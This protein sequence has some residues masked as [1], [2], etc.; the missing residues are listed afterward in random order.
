[1]DIDICSGPDTIC[2]II[3]NSNGN[4]FVVQNIKAAL[5]V[6][7]GVELDYSTLMTKTGP[8]VSLIPGT[9]S[10]LIGDLA[11]GEEVS[12]SLELTTD[13]EILGSAVEY[14][15]D[16]IYEELCEGSTNT[17]S[18]TSSPINVL[19]PDIGISLST[20][21]A[22]SGVIDYEFSINNTVSNTGTND[23]MDVF[24][25]VEDNSNANL[26][27]IEIGGVMQSISTSSI[28][29]F[30]CYDIGALAMGTDVVVVENWVITTC[31]APVQ[32][33][34][35][36]ASFG[37]DG[38]IDCQML[39]DNAFP[40][41]DLTLVAPVSP[42]DIMTS[43]PADIDICSG[44]DTICVIIENT[45]GNNFVVQNIKAALAVP[46]G[47]ELDYST[48]MT[49]TGPMVTLIPGTDSLL[50]GDLADGEEVSFSLELTTDCEILGS[51]VEY[52]VD[53]V[54]EELCEGATNTASA[55]SSPINVLAPDIGIPLSAPIGIS[56]VI[57]Y[58]FSVSNT[59]SNTGLDDADNMFYCVENNSNAS[60]V[61]IEIGGVVQSIST[62]SIPGF[63]CYDIGALAMGTDVVVVENW[64]ITS[65][66]APIQNLFRRASF[67]C[68]GEIDCQMLP[69]SDFPSTVLTLIAPPSPLDI[70]TS[71]A[72]VLDLCSDVDVICVTIEN[73]NGDDFTVQNIKAS[74]I[75]PDG[76]FIDY[77][78]LMT[79]TGPSVSVIPGTDSLLI[80]D[81]EDGQEVSFTLELSVVCGIEGNTAEYQVDVV[82]DELC[83]GITNT[84]TE[85]STQISIRNAE[86]S[87]LSPLIVGN[88]RPSNIFDAI[89]GVEDTLKVP[90]VNAGAGSIDS[91]TYFVVNP[92]S[93]QNVDVLIAG[94][95]LMQTGT[96]GDT[97]FYTITADDIIRDHS[98][99]GGTGNGNGLL[100]ENESL[101]V[102]EVWIGTQ[103]EF[104][105]PDPIRRAIQFG[106]GSESVCSMSNVSTTGV[107]Y[108]FA[109]PDLTY[110]QYAPLIDRPACYSDTV[111]TLALIIINEGNS[112]AKDI[113]LELS[114][115]GNPAA[116]VGSS[117]QYSS[118]PTGPFTSA[119]AIDTTSASGT[120]G[121]NG[122]CAT[123]PGL[124]RAASA[125]L[126][127]V[128]LG[129]GDTLYFIYHLE[130]GC[131]CRV[132]DVDNIYFSSVETV[133]WTNPCDIEL[134][135]NDD[136]DFAEF[137]ARL[138]G[139]LEGESNV[140][141]SGCIDFQITSG[142]ATWMN[143]TFSAEYPDAYFETRLVVDCGID[144]TS[145]TILDPD[146]T[147]ASGL[148]IVQNMDNGFGA[149]DSVIFNIDRNVSGFIQI[150]YTVD[151]SEKPQ[152]CSQTSNLSMQNFFFPDPAC[153]STCEPNASCTSSF[154]FVFSCPACDACNGLTVTELEI[155]RT[156]YC[157]LD[158]DND[159]IADDG[160]TMADAST[161]KGKRFVQGDSLKIQI[162][163]VVNDSMMTASQFWDY[164]FLEFD[165]QTSEFSIIGAEFSVFDASSGSTLI[166][167]S[168]SQFAIGDTMV[169]DLSIPSMIGLGCSDFTGFQYAKG[170]SLFLCVYYSP[171]E[172]LNNVQSVPIT[173]EPEFYLSDAPYDTGT[174]FACNT[175]IETLNQIGIRTFERINISNQDFGG[176]EIS[177]FNIRHDLNYG[178]LG[179]DEFC[180]EIR[181][182]GIPEKYFF[183]K[184]PE[185]E[186]SLDDFGLRL[187]QRLGPDN[188]IISMQS[189][190][191]PISFFVESGDTLCFFVKNYI[192]SLNLPEYSE[193]GIDGGYNIF[194]YP[195]IR[196]NCETEISSF[197][198]CSS[199]LSDVE[200]QVFCVDKIQS[201]FICESFD[202]TGGPTLIA[203][204]LS[205]EVE[206]F[207][208]MSC[209][210]IQLNNIS[211]IDAPFSWLNIESLTGGMVVTSVTEVTG[212]AS[213]LI[214]PSPFGIYQLG[215]TDESSSRMF[216]VCVNVTNCDPQSLSFTSGWDCVGYPET[217][218]E[219]TCNDPSTIDF[220]SVESAFTGQLLKPVG[221]T[222]YDLC[223]TICF[224]QRISS[225]ALGNVNDIEF[226]FDLPAGSD[227][228]PMSFE[229]AYPVPPAGGMPGDTIW[230]FVN[231]PTNIFGNRWS[232]NVTDLNPTLDS[233]GLI[234][235]LGSFSNSNIVL[236]R[237]NAVTTCDF[238]S[239]S[240]ARFVV[241]ATDLCGDELPRITSTGPRLF[242][243][244]AIPEYEIDLS[245]ND[246]TLNPCN[247][248]NATVSIE[249]VIDAD[250]GITTVSSDTIKVILPFG[251]SYVDMSYNPIANST[252]VQPEVVDEGG[253][254]CLFIPIESG[255]ENN[256]VIVFDIDVMANDVGQ[257]CGNSELIIQTYSTA[258]A[259][260][261]GSSCNI[262]VLS[263]EDAINVN[264]E[265][266]D[267]SILSTD[268]TL[269]SMPPSSASLDYEINIMNNGIVPLDA[270]SDLI[271]EFWNDVDGDGLLDTL[272]DNKVVDAS[273]NIM[274]STGGTAIVT[275]SIPVPP[276]GLCNALVVLN[277]LTTC[278]CDLE[279][280]NQ[281]K[282]N[283][284]NE[285]DMMISVCSDEV[286]SVGPDS[287]IG[288]DY[289]WISIDGSNLGALSSTDSTPTNFQ[290]QNTSGLDIVWNFALRSSFDE[291][292]TYDTL[293]V[294]VFSETTSMASVPACEG[295]SVI[296]PGPVEGADF[297]WTP[298][299][300]LD[301]ATSNLPTLNPVQSG[302]ATYNISYTDVNGCAAS[303]E[304]VVNGVACAPG[305]ALGDTV[306]FDINEDGLQDFDEPGIPDVVVFLYNATNTTSGNHIA[307]TTTD[308][309]GFYLFD[310][311]VAGNYV[312]EFVMPDGF[313]FTNADSGDDLNDSDANTSTGRTASIFLPNGT[314]DSTIDAGFIPN[315]NM[316]V[317]FPN[318]SD[319]L[320]DGM[321]HTREVT[322]DVNWTNAIYTYGF[323]GGTD[324][325]EL[326]ILGQSFSIPISTLSGTTSQTIILSNSA[327]IDIF[328]QAALAIDT[329]CMSADSVLNI[330]PC[331]YD[332]ALIKE[333]DDFG[334]FEYG[335]TLTFNI[336][337]ANQGFQ[338]V[339]NVKINDFLPSGFAFLPAINNGWMQTATDTLM[340]F[341]SDT[342]EAGQTTIIPLELE[343]VMSS[344]P[345]AYINTAEIF[346]FTDTL[347]VDR[348][349][350]D[351]DSTPDNDPTNDAGGVVN[352]GSDNS[353]D[354]DGSGAP[355]DTNPNTDED[356]QDPE[357]IR[358]VD[359]AL[360]K[361][362]LTPPPYDYGDTV[363]F[364]IMVTNQ[365]NETVQNIKINDYI[366]NGF[367]WDTSNEPN[368]MLAGTT[369][370]DT[371]PG[372]ISTGEMVTTT[373]SLVIQ[374]A[375]ADQYINV[376]E[377]GYFENEDGD[378]ITEDDIDSQ[379][380][381]T[382]DN[383]SGGNAG[384][385]SD[386]SLNGDGTGNPLDT[387][388]DTDEDD[389]D[390]AFISIPQIDLMK[391]VLG[392]VPS[393]SGAEG[394]F[395][396]TFEFLITNPGNEKL[397]CIQL[398]DDF[399]AQLGGAFEGITVAPAITPVTNAAEVPTLLM[400]Y[401]GGVIDTIFN[402]S[403]GCLNP[404]DSI[405]VQ[406]T[407]EINSLTG[408]SS[409]INEADVTSKSPSGTQITDADT[410]FIMVPDCF[411]EIVCPL[412][413]VNL[414][415]IGDIPVAGTTVAWFNAIDGVS[416][417]V[418]SCGVP[419]ITVNDSNNGGTGCISD[420][421]ILMRQIIVND[422]GD[423]MT[424]PES[425]TCEI[426]YTIIDDVKPVIM[427]APSDLIV[428]CGVDNTAAINAWL[429][430]NGGGIAVDGC[431]SVSVSFVANTPVNT[432]GGTMITPYTFTAMDDCGNSITEVANL[433]LI[434]TTD[435]VLSLPPG[436]D[437]ISCDANPN[438]SAWASTAS[439]T[440]LCDVSPT[441]NFALINTQEICN[442]TTQ[443]TIYTYRFTAVDACGNESAS[444]TATYTVFDSE[445]PTL[446]APMDLMVDCGQ[447]LSLLVA[448]W[449]DDVVPSDNC[450]VA[451]DLV[452]TNDY[453]ASAIM[454]LCGA[455]IPVTW[456]VTNSC[457][458]SSSISSNIVISNDNTGPDLFCQD[459]LTFAV[460]VNDCEANIALPLPNATDCNGVDS[461]KQIN[462]LPNI[463]F[464]EG[465]T[466]VTFQSWDGCGNSTMCTTV[467][468]VIDTENPELV[469]PPSLNQCA[470]NGTC[471]WVADATVNPVSSD[472]STT[473]LSYSV[474]NPDG[475]IS[476]PAM[477]EGYSFMLGSSSVNITATDNANPSNSSSCNFTVT[478]TDCESPT[479]DVCPEVQDMIECGSEDI[480]TWASTLMGSDICTTTLDEDFYILSQINQC[481][482]TSITT[483][484]F[485]VTDEAGNSTS[486]TSTYTTIDT[487]MPTLDSPAN[488]PMVN[489][490]EDNTT[491]FLSWL[492]SNGGAAASDGCS[493][494]LSWT[495]DWNGSLPT[496][497]A[498]MTSIMIT[499]TA[500]D[501][502]GNAVSTTGTYSI[503]DTADPTID[504]PEN[505]TLQCQNINNE[506]IIQNWLNT[507]SGSDDCSDV[508]ITNDYTMML[509]TMCNEALTVR[510]T[511][512]DD[513][514]NSV[515]DSAS[516]TLIDNISPNVTVPAQDT[517]VECDGAGN[518]ADL[519]AWLDAYAN[520]MFADACSEPLD[521]DSLLIETTPGCG[522]TTVLTYA[523]FA[524]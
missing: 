9:D 191:I 400:G 422:P 273:N 214:L 175:L 335:D 363:V 492:N 16:V 200:D 442:A 356:D 346:S 152:G 304:V 128:N 260:C 524:T 45:N 271:I 373:I 388:G 111:T 456:T 14:D 333:V 330:L 417:I 402:G 316:E 242:I 133:S 112:F 343:L 25:C 169:T 382:P 384:S 68:D 280:S 55:T 499:F 70:T 103:C 257:E 222:V 289:K 360:V 521:Y 265:K 301:D 427:N 106:C 164:A 34:F 209:V 148:T 21:N 240:R 170:D 182:P 440:D 189:G 66:D 99:G 509:P 270:T 477:I 368:W 458:A 219:A 347:G 344:T 110:G 237:W 317:I 95:P 349:L 481:G 515:V 29:G 207:E 516:I 326:E 203:S 35:R 467:V 308:A 295:Q 488:S 459:T 426:I 1:A 520:V 359:L 331:I 216:E 371:I 395:D 256:D 178:S 196:G 213:T 433:I 311:L 263:G 73:T 104:G 20:P 277:P 429:T 163:G 300:G 97:I 190:G 367:A 57:G 105:S 46:N 41:T 342:L 302:S 408:P 246:L 327:P 390:P 42:L 63:T 19:A 159:F 314:F 487:T 428:E 319:C 258:N 212:G 483:Y 511:A 355:G 399:V 352:S 298:S 470:D 489:C 468:H 290:F 153:A 364:Q 44:P 122:Q 419:T 167:N 288:F 385:A 69:D 186:Y 519:T 375:D 357:L 37:C 108:G 244:D 114:T 172:P 204:S 80:G 187:I 118:N 411:L 39:P 147:P 282:V 370:M 312:V 77:S 329:G 421:Y 85:T 38:E 493:G 137:D 171:K 508:I 243:R 84:A 192:E 474:T 139:F 500:T 264:I 138:L 52:D 235:S 446:T 238:T 389:A 450:D 96:S 358:V 299:T 294:T 194:F 24:Y 334:P 211:N 420:P 225:T 144:I 380:D 424:T 455:T 130:H 58:E 393:Q 274:I 425:D 469:C 83:E 247:G 397:T 325:I 115:G 223:D 472:C 15:V 17:A 296:L 2:V 328:A 120:I 123:G 362:V 78:T 47:A 423:G 146:G 465:F 252:A 416:A 250:S 348:S 338:D 160:I 351:E 378:D 205:N 503:T 241:R 141:G 79:K 501:A 221:N 514:N 498:G 505:L 413:L 229:I 354:G 482:G 116:I 154:P 510:F 254:I 480:T 444:Q 324:T 272:I 321:D 305:T 86:F 30:T 151:C 512:T 506:A 59:V 418:N 135:E 284:E 124:Y 261:D 201:N 522:I 89:L 484:V 287:I 132:C 22:I 431:S 462:P 517:I 453:D 107:D 157:F 75:L 396:V 26:V 88:L 372:P 134:S 475:S 193:K 117:L 449:L 409:L 410:A 471:S 206:L 476:T 173:Y 490:Q 197:E 176:C 220:V 391:S 313:V 340:Y 266:P 415:C 11:D 224:I 236:L 523:F 185:L 401:N 407:A 279:V 188:D 155:N 150:C 218:E 43:N 435:P 461:T 497:C 439:A 473:T 438:P 248:D 10:L 478:V 143:G 379:A 447:D 23:A 253:I 81:L 297:L 345:D 140:A 366:P 101:L 98:I 54:Y 184:P 113:T 518:T 199:L 376:A 269:V 8:M 32:N 33:L 40:S 350:E 215:L 125:F 126:E 177:P 136:I 149:A 332:L 406:M 486:C 226:D 202:Y 283:I 230:T 403:T 306:W 275:G 276:T 443:Q 398:S 307:T 445:A 448:E 183:I 13:C 93:V 109:I 412:E 56:G 430:S 121:V 181:S 369:A 281:I 210:E 394:N 374:E 87:I 198:A 233:I 166:C 323:L 91:F 291:C 92:S 377:I 4:N 49:K 437:N 3:E 100:D 119:M 262:A 174:R 50:I 310:N 62:S 129:P 72:S 239:G 405:T 259:V 48:L 309:N 145:A 341:L 267:L 127:N 27:S 496:G 5:S 217:V 454:N 278:T 6:P 365:G 82:F 386:G 479:I 434:D 162:T 381:S 51:A 161:A 67:G 495:N 90:V 432:C 60:L 53:V 320:F 336:T 180:N 231:E 318:I 466:T 387:S 12:F 485:I 131:D 353:L 494:P 502:C 7:N 102:C 457:G 142:F 251:L 227:Y 234:G 303:K 392:M 286:I 285:F 76:I 255:L 268:L 451:A 208:P 31:S 249:M 337:L 436:L 513:C 507:A 165:V 383:D 18:A 245:L 36:K 228:V 463:P 195:G 156:N 71:N 339:N 404:G 322:V 452:V 61:S 65:C 361:D 491:N 158:A 232:I 464:S 293:E 74:F 414:E 504:V 292:F 28:P 64:V 460:D 168:L 315:C 94:V 441:V 179:F